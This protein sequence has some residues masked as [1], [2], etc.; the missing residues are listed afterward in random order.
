MLFYF[1]ECQKVE[2]V[3]QRLCHLV[4]FSCV[5]ICIPILFSDVLFFMQLPRRVQLCFY[6][7]SGLTYIATKNGAKIYSYNLKGKRHMIY[8]SAENES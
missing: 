7:S 5:R 8:E 6:Y 4:V 2:L 1:Y 3:S